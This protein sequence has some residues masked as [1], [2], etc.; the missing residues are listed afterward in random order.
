MDEAFILYRLFI[1]CLC[2]LVSLVL[3]NVRQN[4]DENL[5]SYYERYLIKL[6]FLLTSIENMDKNQ[7]EYHSA[8]GVYNMPIVFA[9]EE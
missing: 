7:S 8:C 6:R 2:C 1:K 5:L 4:I 9:A 3:S